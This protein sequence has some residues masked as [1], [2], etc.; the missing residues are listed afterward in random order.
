MRKDEEKIQIQVSDYLRLKYPKVI[1]TFDSSGLRLP[2]GLAVKAKKMRSDRGFPDIMIFEPIITHGGMWR[3]GLFLELKVK[4]SD[5]YLKNGD[6]TVDK[7][8]QE[9]ADMIARLNKRGYYATF[10]FGFDGA[11]KEIDKYLS[12]KKWLYEI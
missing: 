9:Q 6:M 11:I 10:A 1:F 4:L 8:I 12:N 7:H 5:V 2:M 3:H